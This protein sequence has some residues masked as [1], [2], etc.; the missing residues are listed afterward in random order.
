MHF[1]YNRAAFIGMDEEGVGGWSRA[2]KPW[3]ADGMIFWTP[4]FWTGPEN[5]TW[6][7]KMLV[8]DNSI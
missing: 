6:V 3:P 4:I 2:K 7:Q 5:H 1:V 8:H